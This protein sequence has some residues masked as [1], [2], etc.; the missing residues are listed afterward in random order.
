MT[1]SGM[2]CAFFHKTI[3]RL[4]IQHFSLPA[5]S[6]TLTLSGIEVVPDSGAPIGIVQLVHGMCD[7]K[8]RYLPFVE[9][10]ASHGYVCVIHDHRGHGASVKCR[11]DLGYMYS[12]GWRAMVEDVHL[13]NQWIRATYPGLPL[14]LFGHSMGSMVVRSYAKRYADSIDRLIVC[15]CPSYNVATPIALLI[16]SAYSAVLGGH[17]RP[18]LLHWLSFGTFNRPF[19]HEGFPQA[20]VCSDKETLKAY[21]ADPLCMFNFTANGYKNLFDLALDCYSSKDW[22]VT[23]PD[24]PVCFISGAEDP[25]RIS[26]TAFDKSVE[27]MR[28]V[29][30][31]H[32]TAK[33]YPKMRHEILNETEKATVWKDV[34]AFIQ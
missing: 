2:D 25:C 26:D 1:I 12:G 9:F 28:R 19:R 14:T 24:M 13:V 31:R 33:L 27:M 10:L 30:Y 7:H 22:P 11:D 29:G 23:N 3:F 6:D 4:M 5:S 18:H 17:C 21:H 15:G 20:W 16:A 8:E 34:L 32:V